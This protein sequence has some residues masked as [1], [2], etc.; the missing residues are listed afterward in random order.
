[1]P[2]AP[3]RLRISY[4]P[5]RVP[6]LI[7]MARPSVDAGLLRDTRGRAGG[8]ARRDGCRC[9]ED[10]G[11]SGR[12]AAPRSSSRRP[13]A[14]GS[15][16]EGLGRAGLREGPERQRRRADADLVAVLEELRP[17]DAAALEPGAVLA[18]EVL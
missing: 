13:P 17:D 18:A 11:G 4:G 2:P 7:V 8:S 9:A 10:G 16:E 12:D 14:A 15:L 3:R 6:A 1:M 5:T